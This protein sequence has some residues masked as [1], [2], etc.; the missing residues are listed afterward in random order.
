M[1]GQ[2]RKKDRMKILN[3]TIMN[4]IIGLS[5]ECFIC[6]E[7]EFPG[8]G[9][10]TEVDIHPFSYSVGLYE[11]VRRKELPA[12]YAKYSALDE[13]EQLLFFHFFIISLFTKF[14][15]EVQ[16]YRKKTYE[17]IISKFNSLWA[18]DYTFEY[19][20]KNYAYSE[21]E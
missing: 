15:Y 18:G 6:E 3:K 8:S 9:T 17:D 14:A 16:I 21:V 12:E 11:F 19:C 13:N 4:H 10:L 1:T 5:N 20:F 2:N 7:R